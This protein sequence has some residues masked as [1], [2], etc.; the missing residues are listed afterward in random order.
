MAPVSQPD[1]PRADEQPALGKPPHFGARNDSNDSNKHPSGAIQGTAP[2]IDLERGQ[3]T[4]AE[5]FAAAVWG[6][7]LALVV[8]LAL[9]LIKAIAGVISG[10]AALLA[11]A[12]HSGADVANN[13]FVL[14][15]LFYSRRP[16]D[17][18]HPYGHDRAEVLAAIGSAAI[19]CAAGLYF[20]WDSIQKLI[21]GTPVPTTLAL[22]V[23]I[24]TLVVK[25][26]VSRVELAIARD[27]A[28]QAVQADARDN[29][30]D[31]FSSL[32][33]IVGVV[34]ARLG[35]PRLDGLAGVAIAGLILW[36]AVQIAAAASHELLDHNLDPA[37]LARVRVVAERTPQVGAVLGVT[38]RGHSDQFS[39]RYPAAELDVEPLA[40][41]VLTDRLDPLWPALAGGGSLVLCRHPDPAALVH[42]A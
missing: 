2:D 30:A 35:Q 37:L 39:P 22:W 24:G 31:V 13:V 17:E 10:S 7:T 40:E 15:S 11:D 42:R 36:T 27:V 18:T 38:G 1:E 34:G 26:I 32:A 6:P 28:S 20:G 12:G 33:V 16:A 19:L 5:R 8:N 4:A 25:L 21:I 3:R 9:V 23:A 14:A 41:R 29:L